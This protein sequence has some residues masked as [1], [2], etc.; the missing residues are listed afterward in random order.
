MIKTG[1][2]ERHYVEESMKSLFFPGGKTLPKMSLCLNDG[3]RSRCKFVFKS[4]QISGCSFRT[5]TAGG[6]VP[7][8]MLRI[9]AHAFSH[10]KSEQAIQTASEVKMM[11]DIETYCTAFCSKIH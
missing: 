6:V 2:G 11:G 3:S 9:G 5:S 7:S 4:Y 10:R 1:G 8:D